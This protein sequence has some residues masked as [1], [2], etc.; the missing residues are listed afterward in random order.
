[1]KP[2]QPIGVCILGGLVGMFVGYTETLSPPSVEG[3]GLV[4]DPLVL[5]IIGAVIGAQ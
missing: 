2:E 3:S 5:L 4:R 1:M